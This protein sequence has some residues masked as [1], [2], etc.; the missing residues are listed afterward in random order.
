MRRLIMLALLAAA[1]AALGASAAAARPPGINGKIVTNSENRVTGAE[2]IYA[3]DPDGT[4][5]Q[6]LGAGETGQWSPDGT[7][8]AL[9]LDCMWAGVTERGYDSLQI[10]DVFF[11]PFDLGVDIVNPRHEADNSTIRDV[12]G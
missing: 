7:R 3:V 1:I 2:E 4:D 5:R 9:G 6:L 10:T 8:I 12:K 11:G